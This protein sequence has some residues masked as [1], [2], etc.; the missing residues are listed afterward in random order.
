MNVLITQYCI[1]IMIAN[2]LQGFKC[3]MQIVRMW[4]EDRQKPLSLERWVI[5]KILDTIK[6]PFKFCVFASLSLYSFVIVILKMPRLGII[7]S[8][9]YN[10]M[11][12]NC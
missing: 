11:L 4:I 12:M 9:K 1:I 6:N 5:T 7:Y 8:N 2:V 3:S 10:T